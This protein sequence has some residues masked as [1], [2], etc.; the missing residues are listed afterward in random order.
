MRL[1]PF[2]WSSNSLAFALVDHPLYWLLVVDPHLV[3][4]NLASLRQDFPGEKSVFANF[5]L[6]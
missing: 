2:L 5:N 4:L 3:P 1:E 6:W